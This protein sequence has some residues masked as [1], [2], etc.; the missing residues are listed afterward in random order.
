VGPRASSRWPRSSPCS[1]T[2]LHALW[3][4]LGRRLPVPP[5]T[6]SAPATA[7]RNLPP[8]AGFFVRVGGARRFPR[9]PTARQCSAGGLL[10]G[11]ACG[12]RAPIEASPVGRDPPLRA[13]RRLLRLALL[14]VGTSVVRI[15]PLIS[16]GRKGAFLVA[17][18]PSTSCCGAVWSSN[19]VDSLLIGFPCNE[20]VVLVAHGVFLHLAGS[21]VSKH[22]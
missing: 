17:V 4:R 1:P 13:R 21:D 12:G 16:K 20:S 6:S 9:P 22:T 5:S 14:L 7:C 10:G 11:G 19:G 3:S 18:P 15:D 2:F 8:T